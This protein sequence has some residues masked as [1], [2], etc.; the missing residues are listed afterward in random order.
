MN[1]IQFSLCIPTMDRFDD[2]LDDYLEIYLEFKER[3]IIDEIIVCDENGNDYA[4]ILEKYNNGNESTT[5]APIRLYQNET[6]LG[7]LKN[8]ARVVSLAKSTNYIALI[9][10]DNFV[11]ESYFESAKRIIAEKRITIDMPCSLIPM[12]SKPNYEYGFYRDF[13]FDQQTAAHYCH[14]IRFRTMINSGNFVIT[15]AVYQRILFDEAADKVISYDAAY[16]HLLAFQQIPEYRIYM[17]ND[18]EYLHV[19]HDNS[20]FILNQETNGKFYD[21]VIVPQFKQFIEKKT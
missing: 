2:F 19:V 12:Y 9:D 10:S 18:M 1:T 21:Q 17:V 20:N 4:K 6:R 5:T 14:L 11:G 16:L 13:I 3:G 15:P 7:V 8:K